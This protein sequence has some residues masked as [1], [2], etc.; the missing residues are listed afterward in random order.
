MITFLY[1]HRLLNKRSHPACQ[2][3]AMRRLDES[4]TSLSYGRI[5]LNKATAQPG[6]IQLLR[7]AS[8]RRRK[9]L[10][11]RN[12]QPK[13][14]YLTFPFYLCISVFISGKRLY[15]VDSQTVK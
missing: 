7:V 8:S 14:T 13:N 11:T 2:A 9:L 12:S 5:D 15:K 1:L 10:T 6:T 4:C 3:E